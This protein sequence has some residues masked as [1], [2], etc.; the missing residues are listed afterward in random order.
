MKAIF[1]PNTNWRTWVLA[2]IGSVAFILMCAEPSEETSLFA[3]FAVKV[4]GFATAYAA[5][6]LGKHWYD[7]GQLNELAGLEE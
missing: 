6:R 7:K 5:Y 3:D 2:I 4:A 1:N